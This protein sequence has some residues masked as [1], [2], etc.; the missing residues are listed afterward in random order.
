MKKLSYLLSLL[1][2]MTM[3]V[4]TSCKKDPDPVL[5]TDA[6]NAAEKLVGTYTVTNVTRSDDATVD[7]EGQTVT[8]TF[9][10]KDDGTGGTFT[11][12]NAGVLPGDADLPASGTWAWSGS[13]FK[14]VVIN[15]TTLNFTSAL[16]ASPT[17]FTYAATDAKGNFTA[18]VTATKNN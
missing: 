4:F 1:L 5:K 3:I 12:T 11:S 8:L 15:G 9:A 18:T 7:L 2:L 17:I 16:G 6:Q 14:A 10:A 13:N